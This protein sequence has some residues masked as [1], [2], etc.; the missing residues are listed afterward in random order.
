FFVPA[1]GSNSYTRYFAV[2]DGSGSN[3]TDLEHAV[4]G[5]PVGTV[6]GCVT[7]GGAPAPQ[8]RVAVG[9]VVNGAIDS[10]TTIL[11]TG[12]DGC[13]AGT[14]QPGAYGVAGERPGTPYEGGGAT[15]LVH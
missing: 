4:K 15:P 3:A 8:A 12:A 1:G 11:V 14:I 9:P 6:R 5:L 13:Y 7:A 10:V 2:G